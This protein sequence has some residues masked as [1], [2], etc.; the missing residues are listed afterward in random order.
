MRLRWAD[1]VSP[2]TGLRPGWKK[3][4]FC[5]ILN[6]TT[7]KG[8]FYLEGAM[9]VGTIK[10]V[11]KHEYR[12]GLTPKAV[13]AYSNAGHTVFVEKGAGEGSGYSDDLYVK[14]GAKILPTAK[15][16]WAEAE[17]IVK[18][19]EPLESEYGLIRENQILFTYLH[20]APDRPQTDALLKS[21]CIGIAFETIR[22]PKGQLP[23]L[24]PMS[25]I[26]GRLA[27]VE[28]AKYLEKPFGGRGVLLSGVPGVPHAEIVV[29]GAGVVGANAVKAAAGS[30]AHV[31]VMDIDLDKLEYLEDI[32]GSRISTL[33]S[34]PENIDEILPK[35][36][37]VIGAVLIPGSAAP[38]LIKNKHLP[39]MKKGA[40]IVDVAIDQ[41]GCSEASR[42][43]FH[44]APVFVKDGVVNYCVGNMPGAV[45]HTSTNALGNATLRYG[46]S[47]AKLGPEAALKKEDGFLEGLNVYK[48]AL[49]CQGVAGAHN[50]PFTP[51]H[52]ALG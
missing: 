22:G 11:K 15:D 38:K 33:Y 16:V 23:C 19:K 1:A 45:A 46:L 10:E 52:T 49:T 26:A 12:V 6:K 43:T 13:E 37:L 31:T 50:L 39:T 2:A 41:G 3:F 25:Q 4:S 24:K 47:I 44:D 14:A 32:Y 21:K 18:V 7:Q 30:G 5:G 17:M 48:G 34:S 27:V 42:V 40:V 8:V 29:L 36:D 20:L 35:A 51:P 28:G 9:K